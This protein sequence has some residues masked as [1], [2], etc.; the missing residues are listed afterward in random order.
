M[1]WRLQFLE[2][3][4]KHEDRGEQGRVR[5]GDGGGGGGRCIKMLSFTQSFSSQSSIK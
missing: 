4:Q 2:E 1:C 5:G 3:Q